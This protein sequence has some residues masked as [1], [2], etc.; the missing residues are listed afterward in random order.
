[1][2]RRSF[3]S[4]TATSLS[5][6]LTGIASAQDEPDASVELATEDD[7]RPQLGGEKVRPVISGIAEMPSQ[8]ALAYG[9]G[10]LLA[11]RTGGGNIDWHTD[12]EIVRASNRHVYCADLGNSETQPIDQPSLN[13]E[14]VGDMVGYGS[15]D[16]HVDAAFRTMDEWEYAGSLNLDYLPEKVVAPSDLSVGDSVQKMGAR[17]TF[18]KGEVINVDNDELIKYPDTARVI[19]GTILTTEISNSGDSGSAVFRERD[20]AFIGLVFAG[21]D[22]QSFL[23]PAT[24]IE[25]VC[26]VSFLTER[27][28]IER[29]ADYIDGENDEVE[30]GEVVDAI[31]QYKEDKFSPVPRREDIVDLIVRYNNG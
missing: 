20:N 21:N 25:D 8:Y 14:A 31:V 30:R 2:F 5:L 6:S 4:A 3:L 28:I 9:T 19:E 15:Y 23:I 26:G 10:G 17:T 27:E 16:D 7:P 22:T 18:S 24:R 11:E 29:Y 12:D 1:M 13:G